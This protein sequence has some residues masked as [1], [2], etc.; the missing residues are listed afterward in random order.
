MGK[1]GVTRIVNRELC[2]SSSSV[3]AHNAMVEDECAPTVV[4]LA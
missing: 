3:L 1:I 2:R 4:Q